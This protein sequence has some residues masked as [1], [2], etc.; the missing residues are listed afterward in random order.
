M[1]R[2]KIRCICVLLIKGRYKPYLY[3]GKAYRR[4]DTASVEVDRIELN[5]LTLEGNNLYFESLVNEDEDMTFE[6]LEKSLIEKL[7]ITKVNDDTLRTLGL[8][9]KEG[10]LNNAASLLSDKNNC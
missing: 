5:R 3:K 7:G 10:Q 2:K 1:R 4:S 8:Y 6:E 9:T